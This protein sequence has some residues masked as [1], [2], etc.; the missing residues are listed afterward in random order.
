VVEAGKYPHRE[1][2]R[3]KADS[4]RE[5]LRR[6]ANFAQV[7]RAESDGPTSSRNQGGLMQTSPDGYAVKAV[8]EALQALPIGQISEVLE[9]PSSFQIVKVENRRSAGPATFEEVQDKIRSTLND[10][11]FQAERAAFLARLR[12]RTLVTTI[13]DD[14]EFDSHRAS[15]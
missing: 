12:E 7:A 1:Q 10:Q 3:R 9:G 14:T 4:L 15:R 2:A 8:N 11:R 5:K 13:F 6:G